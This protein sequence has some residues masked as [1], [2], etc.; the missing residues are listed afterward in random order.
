MENLSFMDI[1]N[2]PS[3]HQDNNTLKD[4][5]LDTLPN[6]ILQTIPP[7]SHLIK[8]PLQL[9]DRKFIIPLKKLWDQDVP[10][11]TIS[12]RAEASIKRS[13]QV[14]R[15]SLWNQNHLLLSTYSRGLLE[16]TIDSDVSIFLL[17]NIDYNTWYIKGNHFTIHW[18]LSSLR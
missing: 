6:F 3:I 1:R 12:E 10:E 16:K 5:I 11:I 4:K 2:I 17:V 7:E 8:D 15:D 13:I 9:T 18:R 14:D